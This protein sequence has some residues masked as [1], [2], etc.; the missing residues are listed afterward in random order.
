MRNRE[1]FKGLSQLGRIEVASFARDLVK[2][3]PTVTPTRS[4]RRFKR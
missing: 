2:A 3:N 1:D 4:R